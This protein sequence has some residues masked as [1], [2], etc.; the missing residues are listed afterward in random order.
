[1]V[2]AKQFNGRAGRLMAF[3]AGGAAGTY[4]VEEKAAG[5]IREN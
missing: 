3:V 2:L 1:V 4:V 5:K